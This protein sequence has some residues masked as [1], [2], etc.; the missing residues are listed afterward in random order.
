MCLRR[1]LASLV[2]LCASS[3]AAQLM[4]QSSAAPGCADLHLVPAPR[5]CTAAETIQLGSAGISV[6]SDK[7]ADD[8][9]AAKDLEDAIKELGVTVSAGHEG[10]AIHLDRA[11]TAAAKE[12]LAHPRPETGRG[13]ARRGVRDCARRQERESPSS[14]RRR[15]A[16]SMARRQR[17]S[18][19]ADRARMR[20]CWRRRCATGRRCRIAD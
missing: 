19:C 8:A 9:F 12:L 10:A 16:C 3:G 20:C 18:L 2:V 1:S 15:R 13:N 7:N 14:R 11:D 5:E 6:V 17:S 4:A